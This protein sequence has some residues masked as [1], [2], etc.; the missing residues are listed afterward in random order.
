MPG[1]GLRTMS[2]RWLRASMQPATVLGLMMIAACWLALAYILSIERSKSVEGA[3]QQGAN[4]ARLFEEN[5]ISTLDGVDRAMLLLREAYERDPDNFDLRDWSNRTALIGDLTIQM[6]VVGA[7]GVATGRTTL[8][9]GPD[10]TPIYVGG[11]E[12]FQAQRNTDTDRLFIGK[13]ILRRGSDKM[14]FHL[15]RRLRNPDG[16][17]AGVLVASI[18]PN[19]VERFFRA[20]DLGPHGSVLLRSL[21]GVIMASRGVSGMTVGRQVM[22]S[23][24]REALARGASGHYWGNGALMVSTGWCP[25]GP[26]TIFR[27][28]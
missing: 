5:T 23:G 26:P 10:W 15:S 19:F 7:D 9:L 21:D 16:S 1:A 8:A 12:Y 14:A 11:R 24:L 13:P 28:W 3:I 18:D 2:L 17:F 27:F 25:I 22:Q 4:L 6:G 20:V